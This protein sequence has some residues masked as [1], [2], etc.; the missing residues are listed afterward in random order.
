MIPNIY[1]S[2]SVKHSFSAQKVPAYE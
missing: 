1:K 2:A